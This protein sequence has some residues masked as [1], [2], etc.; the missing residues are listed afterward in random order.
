M[1]NRLLSQIDISLFLP[2]VVLVSFSLTTL[3]SMD[4]DFFKNQLFYILVSFTVFIFF[5]HSNIKI[6]QYYSLLLYIASIVLL[7]LVLVLGAETRGA[8]RWIDI[9]GLRI[10]F[11]EV[12]KPFLALSLAGFIGRTER[13]DLRFLLLVF[14][15]SLPV[16]VLIFLQPDLGNAIIYFGVLFATLI[17]VGFPKR[18]FLA[19]FIILV[20][21]SPILWHF[22][23]DYQ[24]QR[25]LTFI[26]PMQDPLGTSYNAVQ[27]IVAVG[28]GM[29]IGKGLGEGTQSGL[30]FLPERHTDFI[31]ASLSEVFGFIGTAIVVI[32]FG[33]ILYRIYALFNHVD[34]RASRVFVAVSFFLILV[35]SFVNISMN[36][37]ILPVVGV[38]LPFVSFG[39]SSILSNFII[40]GMLSSLKTR[41][42]LQ[43]VLEIK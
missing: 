21:A 24:K 29:V 2:V 4:I 20:L 27:S 12:L 10:Q 8:V 11:S 28:S 19:G 38:T 13:R 14:F 18:W 35:Q 39:G 22:L 36:I 16:G 31:F 1:S 40:L 25:V 6:F 23:H 37:G 33:F 30:R 7:I 34:D 42:K 41:E 9:F 15:F 3:F 26:N 43:Q 5:S 17:A 32:T